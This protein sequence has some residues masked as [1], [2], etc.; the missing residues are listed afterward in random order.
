MTI[1]HDGP[2]VPMMQ[3]GYQV[4][5]ELPGD[6]QPDIVQACCAKTDRRLAAGADP[7]WISSLPA[8]AARRARA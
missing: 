5:Q 3:R 2:R 1:R 8:P 6:A 7:F 4:A